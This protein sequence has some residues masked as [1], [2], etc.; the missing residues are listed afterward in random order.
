MDATLG[1]FTARFLVAA[2][3]LGDTVAEASLDVAA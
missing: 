3:T 1:S 2:G